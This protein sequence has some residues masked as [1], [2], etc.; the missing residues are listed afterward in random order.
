MSLPDLV[1]VELSRAGIGPALFCAV[2]EAFGPLPIDGQ[3]ELLN[4]LIGARGEYLC[5]RISKCNTGT[6]PNLLRRRLKEIG[7]TV[8][9]LLRLL[10]RDGAAPQHWNLHPAI[11]LALPQ[12]CRMASKHGPNQIWDP[13]RQLGL[14][15]SMLADL[16]EVSGQADVIFEGPFPKTHGGARREGH[17]PA[18]G[19]VH[20]LIEIYEDMRFRFPDSGPRP[21]FGKVLLQFVRAGLAFAVSIR[22]IWMDGRSQPSFEAAFVEAN[23]PTRLTDA[24][25]KSIFER[26]KPS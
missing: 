9:Q 21:T 15:G 14:L 2:I 10:H 22:T 6:Q 11:T 8:A 5:H 1:L 25:I 18:T 7:T 3:V 24:A 4:R 26:H 23:L 19:L 20:R 13:S 17:E 16:A 12:L